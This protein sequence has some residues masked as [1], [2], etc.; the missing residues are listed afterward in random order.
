MPGAKGRRLQIRLQIESSVPIIMKLD[1]WSLKSFHRFSRADLLGASAALLCILHCLLTPLF[2]TARF[3]SDHGS[4]A[5]NAGHGPV[6]F[7]AVS[8]MAEIS[9]TSCMQVSPLWASFD[10][11]FL[12]LGLLG[13][14]LAPIVRVLYLSW[15]L[16]SLGLILHN[17]AQPAGHS[18]MY[19]GSGSLLVAHLLNWR[20][21]HHGSGE[22]NCTMFVA[23]YCAGTQVKLGSAH[24]GRSSRPPLKRNK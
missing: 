2:F 23:N 12:L 3:L 13:R 11:V 15:G 10:V 22:K 8:E 6:Y 17:C 16:L 19:V 20:H 14:G 5:S 1:M 24:A 9:H 7:G 4:H 21:G 18:L